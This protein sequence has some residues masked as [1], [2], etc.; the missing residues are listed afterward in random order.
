VAEVLLKEEAGLISG[1][2]YEMVFLAGSGNRAAALEAGTIDA[3]VIFGPVATDLVERSGGE[4]KV[5]GGTWNVL[6]PMLWE[7]IAFSQRFREENPELAGAFVAAMLQAYEQFYEGDPAE[8]VALIEDIPEPVET[9]LEALQKE[10]ELYQ[11]IQ[12][13]PLDGGIDRE[14]FE[15]MAEFLVEVGQLEPDQVVA[16]EDA[17]DPSFVEAALALG[18]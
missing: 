5:Y 15:R 14:S 13:Y 2:D 17:I 8:M 6:D 3:A 4:F 12:L 7:G 18:E 10:F 11:Q 1:T 9:S 16:Y